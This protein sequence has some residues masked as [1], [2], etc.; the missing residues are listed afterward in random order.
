MSNCS[1]GEGHDLALGDQ[2]LLR[3]NLAQDIV[4]LCDLVRQAPL[5]PAAKWWIT[6]TLL[7][8]V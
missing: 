7:E 3:E 2:S 6:D 5:S 4:T 1:M 8:T